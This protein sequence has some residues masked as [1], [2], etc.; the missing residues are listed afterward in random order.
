MDLKEMKK[1]LRLL[2]RHLKKM[3]HSQVVSMMLCRLEQ[4][5]GSTIF[6]ECHI[7]KTFCSIQVETAEIRKIKYAI[8]NLERYLETFGEI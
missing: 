7:E 3:V 5:F 6:E 4:S 8:K 2:Q 1:T